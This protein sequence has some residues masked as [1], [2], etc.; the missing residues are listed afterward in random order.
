MAIPF[1]FTYSYLLPHLPHQ[2]TW[3]NEWYNLVTQLVNQ[4]HTPSYCC[5]LTFLQDS[6]V[7]TTPKTNV[8]KIDNTLTERQKKN[9]RDPVTN[10]I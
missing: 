10:V 5:I 1:L 3:S 9:I 6:V 8:N 7:Q 4:Q 2:P